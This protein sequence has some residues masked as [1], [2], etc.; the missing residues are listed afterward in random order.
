MKPGLSDA[1]MLRSENAIKRIVHLEQQLAAM[2]VNSRT[3]RTLTAS[4]RIEADAYRKT[5]DAAFGTDH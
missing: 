4:I 1:R 3:R 5:L 2:P